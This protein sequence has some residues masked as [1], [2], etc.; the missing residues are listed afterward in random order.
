MKSSDL[1][2]EQAELCAEQAPNMKRPLFPDGF[3]INAHH[4]HPSARQ[5]EPPPSFLSPRALCL[6]LLSLLPWG[7]VKGPSVMGGCQQTAWTEGGFPFSPALDTSCGQ[8]STCWNVAL[9]IS[10]LRSQAWAL[11]APGAKSWPQPVQF[12]L[13]GV[14][15]TFSCLSQ[16]SGLLSVHFS[17]SLAVLLFELNLGG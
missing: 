12:C 10:R 1:P 8:P 13:A 6:L 4:S 3:L 14:A 15:R 17:F 16:D 9:F 2:L 11:G 7:Q 5:E